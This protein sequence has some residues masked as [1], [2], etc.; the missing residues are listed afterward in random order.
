M[1]PMEPTTTMRV[2]ID[3][4][5]L[6]DEQ[7]DALSRLA[8]RDDISAGYEPATSAETF[9]SLDEILDREELEQSGKWFDW[10]EL[11]GTKVLI[12]HA[13]AAGP[14]LSK[15]ERAFRE[16]HGVKFGQALST[17]AQMDLFR[18]ALFGTV[19]KGWE[20]ITTQGTEIPFTEEAFKRL[21]KV[22]RFRAFVNQKS[23]RLEEFREQVLDD[24]G[25]A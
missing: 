15:L 14:T 8:K 18:D 11:P 17:G 1:E 2:E 6:D 22:R 24:A 12:A 3:T 9:A 4:D 25:E 19:V 16:K 13:S 20:G 7:L 5:D 21:W 23:G 10:P